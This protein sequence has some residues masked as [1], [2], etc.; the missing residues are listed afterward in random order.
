M[1]GRDSR[2]SMPARR[3]A[4]GARGGTS[5][6]VGARR[7]TSGHVEHDVQDRIPNGRGL[8]K[9]ESQ[10]RLLKNCCGRRGRRGRPPSSLPTRQ[11][12]SRERPNKLAG[13]AGASFTFDVP[14][15]DQDTYTSVSLMLRTR[16]G[17][18]RFQRYGL[19]SGT[20]DFLGPQ[21]F[22]RCGLSSPRA[23]APERSATFSRC[24]AGR[25]GATS[26]QAL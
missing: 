25:I 22:V 8:T 7:G 5:R 9:N 2:R 26:V 16:C 21:L 10:D 17:A 3:A 15:S 13:R 23:S 19:F 24:T 11:H 6:H 4:H 20:M 18:G 1:R 12:V 14:Q